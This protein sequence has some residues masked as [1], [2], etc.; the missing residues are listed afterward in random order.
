VPFA[1]TSVKARDRLRDSLRSPRDSGSA[2]GEVL[3]YEKRALLWAKV[4]LKRTVVRMQL[5]SIVRLRFLA[6][7]V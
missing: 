6:A 1:C 7:E 4:P 2:A 5:I 3:N